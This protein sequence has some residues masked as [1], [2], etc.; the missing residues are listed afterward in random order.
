MMVN[1]NVSDSSELGADYLWIIV[2]A[3]W[4]MAL[5]QAKTMI[6][7]KDLPHVAQDILS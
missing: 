6:P 1:C 7:N 4:A 5:V 2:K 3:R